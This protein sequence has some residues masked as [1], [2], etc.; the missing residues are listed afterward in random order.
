MS[1]FLARFDDPFLQRAN[2]AKASHF[3]YKNGTPILVDKQKTYDRAASLTPAPQPPRP[4][5]RAGPSPPHPSSASVTGPINAWAGEPMP[6]KVEPK[7]EVLPAWVALSQ[8]VLRF[9]GYFEEDV[10]E[11]QVE[12]NR[13]RKVHIYYYLEDDSMQV[14]AQ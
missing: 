11:S 14:H 9:S 3:K 1:V 6:Q 10:P 12:A 8:K 5:A 4:P 7:P 13:V 2:F